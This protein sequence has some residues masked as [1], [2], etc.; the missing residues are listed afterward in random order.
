MGL[1]DDSSNSGNV[2]SGIQEH[3]KLHGVPRPCYNKGYVIVVFFLELVHFVDKTLK[4]IDLT[5]WFELG[6]AI[7]HKIGK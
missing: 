6:I 4:I 2:L 5:I 3:D 7:T 1:P